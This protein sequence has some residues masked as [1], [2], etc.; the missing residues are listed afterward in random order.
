M[1]RIRRAN[2]VLFYVRISHWRV[3]RIFFKIFFF[4]I[5]Y[6][7]VFICA[8]YV[9]ILRFFKQC[10]RV[11]ANYYYKGECVYIVIADAAG[12]TPGMNDRYRL[13]VWNMYILIAKDKRNDVQE[14][15]HGGDRF[16]GVTPCCGRTEKNYRSKYYRD[17][18]F[19]F[20][21]PFF[22]FVINRI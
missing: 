3:R 10:L 18:P 20:F 5:Y 22:F 7:Y 13:I 17:K 14:R 8:T 11:R 6:C 1:T 9:Q 12:R 21:S 4:S 2:L 15:H 16:T 19:L